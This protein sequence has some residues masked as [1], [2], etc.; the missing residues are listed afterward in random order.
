MKSN[1]AEIARYGING[2]IATA[3]HYAVLTVNLNWL[4]FKSAGS[5][6]F[7]AALFGIAISFLGSRYFVFIAVKGGIVKQAAKFSGLY[8][9]IAILHGLFLWFWTDLNGLDY[10]FGFLLATAMQMTLGYIGNKFL[11]FRK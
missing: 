2:V 9:S 11:V 10:R 1:V 6:N 4:H 5:A 8:G 3:L 7:I